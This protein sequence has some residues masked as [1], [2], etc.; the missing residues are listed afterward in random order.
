MVQKH[1][2][3]RIR[4]FRKKI[5][6]SQE[7]F[8]LDIGMDRSYFASIEAGKRNVAIQN[9]QKIAAG[10]GISI[11]ELLQG[12]PSSAVQCEPAK[13]H[14]LGT[15]EASEQLIQDLYINL[16]NEVNAWSKITSQTPQARMGYIRAAPG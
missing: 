12:V 4:L 10:L 3:E 14:V 16:R 9:I 8:A 11:S 2:G 1:L 5:G 6:A 7:K 13:N 15:L